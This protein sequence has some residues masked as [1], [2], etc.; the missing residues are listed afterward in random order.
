M[1]CRRRVVP[2]MEARTTNRRQFFRGTGMTL[3]SLAG[4]GLDLR[5]ARAAVLPLKAKLRGAR[6][7]PS[8]CPY[9]AVGCGQIVSVRG[10]QIV[11]IEGNPDSPIN[12]GTLCPK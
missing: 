6:E 3:G 12:R 7:V 9:C 2:S 4:L 10:G 11:N 1:P 8:I 5:P